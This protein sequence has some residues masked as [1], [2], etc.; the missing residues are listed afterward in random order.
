MGQ[1]QLRVIGGEIAI[2]QNIDI[3]GSRTPPFPAFAV[4]SSL[5]LMGKG[6]QCRRRQSRLHDDDG[7]QEVRLLGSTNGVGLDEW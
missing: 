3:K 6:Q 4:R 5:A 7:V 1:R 2:G